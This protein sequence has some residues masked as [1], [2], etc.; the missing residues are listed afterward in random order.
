MPKGAKPGNKNALGNRGNR[1]A[2]AKTKYKRE[3]ADKL[4]DFFSIEP[5]R[6]IE[7]EHFG[8]DGNFAYTEYKEKANALPTFHK[9]CDSIGIKST[10]T[11]LDWVK[12]YPE[13]KE[14]HKTAKELQKHFLIA[15]GLAGLYNPTFAIFTAKNITDMRDQQ[16]IDLTSQGKAMSLTPDQALKLSQRDKKSK[17]END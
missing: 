10:D 3:Y 15:N 6:E 4:V 13:F 12:K 2:R 17:A 11:L 7:I 9:F 5:T 14:A 1:N 16:N 8:K